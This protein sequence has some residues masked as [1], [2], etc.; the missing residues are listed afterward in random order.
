VCVCVCVCVCVRVCVRVR[1]CV[2]ACVCVRAC[3]RACVRVS[4]ELF[5]YYLTVKMDEKERK[6]LHLRM[7]IND[8]KLNC[9]KID[10][11]TAGAVR[12]N[13]NGNRLR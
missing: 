2:C 6:Y 4:I 8:T 13:I 5:L 11:S 12:I 3:V 7:L 9:Y 1:A 10:L